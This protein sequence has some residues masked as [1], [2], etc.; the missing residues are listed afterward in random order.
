MRVDLPFC[1][2]KSC[3]YCADGNCTKQSEHESCVYTRLKDLELSELVEASTQPVKATHVVIKKEDALKYL[4]Y[5]DLQN[6]EDIL[7][8][9]ANGRKCDGKPPRKQLLSLQYR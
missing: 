8:K 4:H 9:I 3:R 7:N 2:L 5:T 1:N 6:L